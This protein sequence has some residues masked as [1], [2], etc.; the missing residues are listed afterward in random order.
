MTHSISN[1][2]NGPRPVTGVNSATGTM[3][4]ISMVNGI[5]AAALF[6]VSAILL[7]ISFTLGEYP[8]GVL[9]LRLASM[10]VAVGGVVE[11]IVSIMLRNIARRKQGEL[12]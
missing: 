1:N 10:G 11:L 8:G 6:G 3:H 7:F 5:V 2:S 12:E 4:T 9:G